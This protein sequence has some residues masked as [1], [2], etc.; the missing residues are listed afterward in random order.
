VHGQLAAVLAS[1][2]ALATAGVGCGAPTKINP[3][4]DSAKTGDATRGAELFMN[5]TGRQ[6]SCA[7]CH[8][9]KAADAQGPFAPNLDQEGREYQTVHLSDREVRKLVLDFV[10]NGRCG[11]DPNDPSRC[12][13]KNLVTG[14]DAIDVATYVGQCAGKAGRPGCHPETIAAEG[15]PEAAVGLRLYRSFRCVGC[16]SVTGNVAIGPTFKGLAGSQVKIDKGDKVTADD[17]YLI[18]SITDP[19][20]KIVDGF[21]AGVMT[22]TIAPG[23]V[24]LRQA[25]AIV[26]FLKTLK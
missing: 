12:M 3:A 20:R 2:L 16:H 18:E 10:V 1:V 22:V 4:R 9:M 17:A 19:D 25:R 6:V 11:T 8:A 23:T 26:A 24:S 21:D 13:P 14:Q 15:N 7:F 5:G